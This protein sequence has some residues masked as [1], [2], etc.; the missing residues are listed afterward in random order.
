[1]S[2]AARPPLL[3]ARGEPR[4]SACSRSRISSRS[5]PRG[6]GRSGPSTTS[7]SSLH[8][9]KTLCVV[10]EIGLRQ[11]RH[12]ALDPADRRPARPRDR[13]P[14]PA[15]QHRTVRRRTR[16]E[17]EHTI[18]LAAPP[19]ALRRHP[20][21]PRARRGD[22]LPG[23][24]E[25]A[26]AGPPHRRPD[27]RGHPPPRARLEEARRA[28]GRIEL[29]R[30]VEIPRPETAIDRYPFEYSG[31]MRQRAMI[32]V[33][34]ACNPSVL[35]A[36][37]PTTA[38]DVTIQAEILDLIRRSRPTSDMAVMFITHDMGVVAEIADEIAVM[39][40][41][42]IVERGDPFEIFERPQHDYTRGLLGAVRELDRPSERRL[43]MRAET[44][45]GSAHP[46]CPGRCARSF[47][48]PRDSS[49]CKK[50]RLL[51]VDDARAGAQGRREPRHRRRER[52][53]QDD[54]R[55]L[56]PA[57]LSG[58]AAARSSTR[59]GTG[60]RSTSRR[61]PTASCSGPGATSARSSRTR[62]PRSTRA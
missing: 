5:S 34:L 50:D 41:G 19:S 39:R 27:R 23:A 22:D 1:M 35:I 61:S 42:K 3:T 49:A 9:G 2:A 47:P 62:S 57:R 28:S 53:R 16:G 4:E 15:P 18:D 32:A 30:K 54:A 13:R 8:A 45:A 51:A 12:G 10:G 20:R 17:E 56:H 31:G 29:L 36:D 14:G 52:L 43:A 40:F 21:H 33:A 44:A 7:A 24:D 55:P 26:L 60:G 25:L 11:E 48:S 37:E 38:L 46:R 59:A 6:A 58:H